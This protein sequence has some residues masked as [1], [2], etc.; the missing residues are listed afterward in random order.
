[1]ACSDGSKQPAPV[2][3]SKLAAQ[4]VAAANNGGSAPFAQV[5]LRDGSTLTGVCAYDPYS[6]FVQVASANAQGRTVDYVN[7]AFIAQMNPATPDAKS[8]APDSRP[9]AQPVSAVTVATNGAKVEGTLAPN[10]PAGCIAIVPNGANA[11]AALPL[12][13]VAR[14]TLHE[15]D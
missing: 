15:G 6:H 14:L 12:Q 9:L 8:P 3:Q 2:T 10:A 11:P 7:E 4:P 5:V 1:C 13:A